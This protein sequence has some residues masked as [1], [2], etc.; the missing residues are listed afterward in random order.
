MNWEF[1]IDIYTL[2]SIKEI[3][4][5]NLRHSTGSFTSKSVVTTW[6]GNPK[7][8]YMYVYSYSFCCAA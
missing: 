3:T 2:L 1:G 4:S 5:E 6:E 8:R 7:G